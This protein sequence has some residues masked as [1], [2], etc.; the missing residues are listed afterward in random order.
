MQLPLFPAGSRMINPSVGTILERDNTLWYLLN[1][2]PVYTH[3][4]D[5]Q[6]KFRYIT[7]H[8]VE[9]GHC[10]QAD[11]VRF[12]HVS[13]SSV[14]RYLKIYRD[15]GENGFFGGSG[16]AGGVRYKMTPELVEKIQKRIDV[17]ESQNSIAKKFKIS[18]GTIRYQIQQ[19][20]LKKR[21]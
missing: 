13:L 20:V 4:S 21:Q 17:G 16:R 10:S 1:G 14:Q 18:E 11:I 5:D 19:G 9:L 15:K 2:L 8:L 3:P 12:F 7:S 6:N